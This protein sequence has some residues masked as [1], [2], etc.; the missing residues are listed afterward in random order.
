[1]RVGLCSVARHRQYANLYESATSLSF[2]H[3]LS[4]SQVLCLRQ[5]PP[6]L[7]PTT[8]D[9]AFYRGDADPQL[10]SNFLFRVLMK[11]THDDR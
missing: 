8:Q 1:M 11:V 6:K 4:T 3:G 5:L 9:P 7:T 2:A 10:E